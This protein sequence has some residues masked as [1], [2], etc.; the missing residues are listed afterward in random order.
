M[1]DKFEEHAKDTQQDYTR[2]HKPFCYVC[3]NFDYK[4]E[5]RRQEE[6]QLRKYGKIN[7][8]EINV[9]FPKIEN[10]IGEKR[11]DLIKKNAIK[12]NKVIDGVKVPKLTGYLHDFKCKVRGCG[13]SV[14]VPLID[15]ALDAELKIEGENKTE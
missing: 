14:E 6:D 8:A 12:E 13:V 2:L 3:I 15:E 5:L 11:F 10:Y 1:L 7:M 4:D 9:E